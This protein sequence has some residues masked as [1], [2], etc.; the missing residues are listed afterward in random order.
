MALK[1]KKAPH[2][3]TAN[4]VEFVWPGDEAVDIDQSDLIAWC[5]YG[6]MTGLTMKEGMEAT[7]IHMHPLGSLAMDEVQAAAVK[8]ASMQSYFTEGFRY[9]FHKVE[10]F[11]AQWKQG[12]VRSLDDSSLEIFAE[13]K[14]DL[15][16]TFAIEK[17]NSDRD[18]R[19]F[20]A[21]DCTEEYSEAKL[22]EVIGAH[23]LAMSFRLQ[24]D[25]A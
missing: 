23:V 11:A 9:G 5:Q 20:N 7:I 16:W 15:P 1:L 24:R 18:G 19:P 2:Q 21:E 12:L 10:G 25:N 4:V 17:L 13:E 14:M 22:T 8:N 6:G 3:L